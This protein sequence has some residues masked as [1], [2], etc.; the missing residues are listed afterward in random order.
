[1]AKSNIARTTLIC[2]WLFAAL[3]TM[4]II[5]QVLSIH[6]R[7]ARIG[8]DDYLLFTAYLVSVLLVGQ[9]TW[10]VVDEGQGMHESDLS[11]HNQFGIVAKVCLDIFAMYNRGQRLK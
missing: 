11:H 5:I 10:A 1:M 4:S 8:I 9:T 2:S 7:K 3:A 6:A